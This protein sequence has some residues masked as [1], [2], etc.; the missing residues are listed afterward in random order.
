ME[1]K[2]VTVTSRSAVI[3][4]TDSGKFY[5]D[6][7]YEIFINDKK[8]AEGE[9]VI[10]S[11]YG[12]CPDTEYSVR[13]EYKNQQVAPITFKTAYE[14]V[15]LNV[16]EFGAYGDGKHDDTNAIQCA[17]MACP[18][19]SRVLVPEGV[20]KISS[21]FLK[22]D[23][24]LE[25][26][27]GAV[28]SAFTDRE[29]FPIL[30]GIIQSY[31]E[32]KDYNLGSWEGNPLDTFSAI[33]CGINVENVIITGEGVID[34]CTS[35]E[36]WWNNCKVREI[37]WRPR[38][39][40]INHCKNVM[41]HGVT[42]QN[43]PSW[44]IHPYFSEHLKFIDV[45]IK[46]PANSHNTDGLDPESCTDVLVLGTYISVGD[47]C[48]AIKSGKIYMAEKY[49]VPTSNMTVR[50]CCMRDGHGAVTVGSE[51]AAGVKNVHIKDCLFMNTDRGLRVKTRRGRGRLSVLD[52]ISFENIDMD[53][54]MTP[55]VVNSF[56]FCDPD[57]KTEYVGSRKA[58]PVDYRTPSIKSLT[59]KNI[60]AT[61]C[62][63]AGAYIYGLPESKIEKLTFEN[64]SFEY[65][66]DAKSGVAAMML[67]C[68]EASRQGLIVNNIHELI[69]KN[70][71]IT[72]CEGEPIIAENVEHL[73]QD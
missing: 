30:P 41:M 40:F 29:K 43:S 65:A 17:I 14:F 5:T 73:I 20:Y 46:N 56:Y 67:G 52:D 50:Q 68:D 25:L 1:L 49:Q 8:Y 53:N 72:G 69:L 51:I 10:T 45:K 23:L 31:D 71:K 21:V 58:L 34:G 42:V 19:D 33:I 62:H 48:I 3:E 15:T 22:S 57:G 66:K 11:L 24:T 38:L 32:E 59:F 36:N 26:A 16:R 55:F 9:K 12:L 60:K 63:V 27:A 7:K 64:I 6:E 54:V 37:A 2:L 47:D 28:L 44:T 4:L 39:F 13:V 35:F 18:K 61:N 70:V